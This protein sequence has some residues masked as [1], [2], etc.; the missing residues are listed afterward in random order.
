M[1]VVRFCCGACHK[2]L[3]AAIPRSVVL[4]GSKVATCCKSCG[5]QLLLQPKPRPVGRNAKRNRPMGESRAC[6]NC[7]FVWPASTHL[8]RFESYQ[9]RCKNGKKQC[10]HAKPRN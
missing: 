5:K 3:K 8:G 10:A 2:K 4:K 7:A 6:S 9:S 1:L